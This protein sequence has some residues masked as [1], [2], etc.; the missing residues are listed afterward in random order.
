LQT[1]VACQLT[2]FYA[3][4]LSFQLCQSEAEV[5]RKQGALSLFILPFP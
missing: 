5:P 4:P 2:S 3:F 1:A